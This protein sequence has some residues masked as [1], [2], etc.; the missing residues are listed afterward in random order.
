[1]DFSRHNTVGTTTKRHTEKISYVVNIQCQQP[2]QSFGLK[3]FLFSELA[4]TYIFLYAQQAYAVFSRG[5]LAKDTKRTCVL[6]V[7][8]CARPSNSAQRLMPEVILII[9]IVW[10]HYNS[11]QQTH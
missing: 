9:S 4:N 3:S 2:K 6:H 5:N 7:Q 8:P 11:G 10:I 1:M